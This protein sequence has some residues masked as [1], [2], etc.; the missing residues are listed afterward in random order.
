MDPGLELERRLL[1]QP[2]YLANGFGNLRF[3]CREQP[4]FCGRGQ[5]RILCEEHAGHSS[6]LEQL[7]NLQRDLH[8]YEGKL[9][10]AAVPANH[11]CS[12]EREH[13]DYSRREYQGRGLTC[14]LQL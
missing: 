5:C 7:P 11:G 6:R 2:L 14:D 9:G 10:S 8:V 4:V 3:Q 1:L 12:Y 13:W